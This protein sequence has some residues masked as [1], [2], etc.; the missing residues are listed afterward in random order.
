VLF[1]VATYLWLQGGLPLV[2]MLL[3]NGFAMYAAFTPLA[4]KHPL[5]IELL[6]RTGKIDEFTAYAM[7]KISDTQGHTVL[8]AK[9]DGPFMLVDLPPGRYSI[10]SCAPSPSDR[11]RASPLR[12][13]GAHRIQP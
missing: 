6:E 10:Q 8:D 5:A 13:L 7:V 4:S 12:G 11:P 3:L 1:A 9:A 2:A